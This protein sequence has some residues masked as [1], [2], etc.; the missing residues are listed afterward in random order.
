DYVAKAGAGAGTGAGFTCGLAPRLK[1]LSA[2]K[3]A[4]A[5]TILFLVL[6]KIFEET[7]GTPARS[8]TTR[9]A[10]PAMMPEPG[11]AGFSITVA[12]LNFTTTMLRTVSLIIGTLMMCFLA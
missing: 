3:A 5:T 2:S 6:P 7:F 10:A 4:L 8:K 1:L 11:G 12:A 9:S